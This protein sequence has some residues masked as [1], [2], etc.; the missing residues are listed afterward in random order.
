[1]K[2]R[3]L[4]PRALRRFGIGVERIPIAGK[5]IDEGRAGID[6]IA[7]DGV[8]RAIRNDRG[9]VLRRLPSKTA[10]AAQKQRLFE[11]A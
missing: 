4:E 9:L 2:D 3:P 11:P 7:R 6:R 8:R 1:M 5:T 10:V